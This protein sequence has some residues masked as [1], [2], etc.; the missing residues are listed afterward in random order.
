MADSRAKPSRVNH[1][2]RTDFEDQR[3]PGCTSW[4]LSRAEAP[5]N[6]SIERARL[7]ISIVIE[8]L[9]RTLGPPAGTALVGETGGL[10]IFEPLIR[11]SQRAMLGDSF[12]TYN[13]QLH[14]LHCTRPQ[15]T[16]CFS[17]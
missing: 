12:S 5:R 15:S 11:H 1:D 16:Y 4:T 17:D 7:K 6:H 10:Q 13:I 9:H 2:F 3:L 14:G 8:G